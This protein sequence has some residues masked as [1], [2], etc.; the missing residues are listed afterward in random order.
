[1]SQNTNNEVQIHGQFEIRKYNNQ[2]VVLITVTTCQ[3]SQNISYFNYFFKMFKLRLPLP[4]RAK[5]PVV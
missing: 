3:Q 5:A 2:K 1:M 4:A